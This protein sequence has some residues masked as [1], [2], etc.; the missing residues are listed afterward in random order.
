MDWNIDYHKYQDDYII[1]FSSFSPLGEEIG[2]NISLCK[3]LEDL[4]GE[5]IAEL[6]SYVEDF[7]AEEHAAMWFD[8]R[9]KVSGVPQ[10]LRQLLKDADEIQEMLID[11]LKKIK[12]ALE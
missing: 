3:Y 11:L 6:E 1:D 2:V 10:S 4:E 7:D 8:A 9:H 12:E 5:L